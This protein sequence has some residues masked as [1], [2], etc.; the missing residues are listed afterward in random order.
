MKRYRN[1]C[2]IL[3]AA[4]MLAAGALALVF[5]PDKK[6]DTTEAPSLGIIKSVGSS[7]TLRVSPGEE[8]TL[9]VVAKNGAQVYVKWGAERYDAKAP[10]KQE[11]YSAYFVKIKMPSSAEAVESMGEILAVAALDGQT[12]QM[13][14]PEIVIVTPEKRPVTTKETEPPV[15]DVDNFNPTYIDTAQQAKPFISDAIGKATTNGHTAPFTGNQMAIVTADRADTKPLNS[16]SDYV[17][18]FPALARGTMDFVVGESSSIDEDEGTTYYYYDLASGIKVK[19]DSVIL[20]PGSSM[21]ENSLRLNS[22]Y[23]SDGELTIRLESTW[24]VPYFVNLENQYYYS[25]HG[26]LFNV[27]DFTATG[28]TITFNYTTGATGEFDCAGSD[29]VSSCSWSLSPENKTAALRFNFRQPGQYY[30]YS[31]YYEGNETVITIKGKPKSLAGSIV[32]LDPGHGFDDAGATGLGEAVKES[33][34]NILIAYQ[35]K[36]VLEQQGVTVYMTRYGDDDISLE[37]RKILARNLKPDLFVSIHANGSENTS[38]IGTSAYYYKP[39]SMSLASNIY[40]ELLAVYRNNLYPSQP[41]LYDDIAGEVRYYPFSVTR[42]EE[43]P[44]ALVEV[45]FM[46]NDAECYMLTRTENQQLIGQAIARG[47]CVTLTQ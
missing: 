6:P 16:E 38:S 18:Y 24:K 42:L 5:K 31:L 3:L 41:E 30:G 15:Y 19:R 9:L 7:D 40:Y 21:P 36:T 23:G 10:T 39:F 29:V 22:V 46:T 32:V 45:G 20:Q 27:T 8:V 33:D 14:G 47:I 28:L 2:I 25:S 44:S 17:P 11:G 12:E 37:G 34:I 26:K 1:L 35:V 13:K 4:V 43:C